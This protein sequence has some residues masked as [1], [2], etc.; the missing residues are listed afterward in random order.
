MP[1][2]SDSAVFSSDGASPPPYGLPPGLESEC[3]RQTPDY[4]RKIWKAYHER[5]A[6]VAEQ[7]QL[8]RPVAIDPVLWGE[9]LSGKLVE[10][11]EGERNHPRTVVSG[12]AADRDGGHCLLPGTM[13]LISCVA[14]IRRRPSI[15]GVL[16]G[17]DFF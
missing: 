6:L 9:L 8:S 13:S 10:L 15:V 5:Q 11:I 16:S 2:L 3:R 7:R 17:L 14:F 4:A 1:L 12:G